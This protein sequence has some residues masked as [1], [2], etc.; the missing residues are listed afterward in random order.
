MGIPKPLTKDQAPVELHKIYDAV[1]AEAGKMPNLFGVIARFPEAL[2][3]IIQFHDAVMSK[4]KIEAK[5]KELAYL[6]TSS[7]NDCRY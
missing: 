1:Q 7:I 5:F 4:G 2:K 6:K 3:T